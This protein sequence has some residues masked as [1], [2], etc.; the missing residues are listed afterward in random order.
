[1]GKI[2]IRRVEDTAFVRTADVATEENKARYGAATMSSNRPILPIDG[3]SLQLFEVKLDPDTE[4][5]PRAHSAAEI[6]VVTAGEVVFGAQRCP[7]GTAVFVDANTLYGFR[8]GPEGCR[9]YNFR[10]VP[11]RSTS[12]RTSSCRS[13]AR[14]RPPADADHLAAG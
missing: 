5:Q 4:I 1:M 2:T 8:A 7:V 14:H 10:G 9:F 12:P 6:I 11:Q 3:E 13:A